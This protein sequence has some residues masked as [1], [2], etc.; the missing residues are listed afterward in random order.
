MS[1]RVLRV[2]LSC[3]TPLAAV[4]FAGC[5]LSCEVGAQSCAAPQFLVPN[6]SVWINTCDP[7]YTAVIVCGLF[8]SGPAAVFAVNIG[9]PG[10][11]AVQVTPGF[12]HPFDPVIVANSGQ[13]YAGD[14]PLIADAAGEG[15]TE[16]LNLDLDS[17][18]YRVIVTTINSDAACGNAQVTLYER[19]LGGNEH[20]G[21]FRVGFE[22]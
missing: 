17:G 20:D 8:V 7:S 15:G 10:T 12:V 11:L 21:I 14:C 6:T 22:Y 2:G 13:C 3:N 1:I 4:L 18:S 9:Y 5:V 16:Q 19:T